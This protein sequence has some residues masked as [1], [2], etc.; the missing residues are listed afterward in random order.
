[1][2]W[3][4]SAHAHYI[5][6]RDFW[7]YGVVRPLEDEIL[8]SRGLSHFIEIG[9]VKYHDSNAYMGVYGKGFHGLASFDKQ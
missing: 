9:A 6:P 4:L 1:M 8:Q 3:A 5:T 2:S 7:I